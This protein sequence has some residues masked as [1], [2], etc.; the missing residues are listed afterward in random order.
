LQITELFDRKFEEEQQRHIE[1]LKEIRQLQ[2][3]QAAAN[4]PSSNQSLL[5]VQDEDLSRFEAFKQTALGALGELANAGGNFRDVMKGAFSAVA[6]AAQT[7]LSAFILTGKG[8]GQAFKQ[9]AADIIASLAIQSAI[10]AIFETAE[11]FAALAIGDAAGAALHFT[12]AKIYAVVAAGALAVGLAIGAAGGLGGGNNGSQAQG[13]GAF[14]GQQQGPK[15][16]QFTFGDVRG[17]LG[18]TPEDAEFFKNGKGVFG[19]SLERLLQEVELQRLEHRELTERQIAAT[20][21]H[22][23]AAE[24]LVTRINSIPPEDVLSV[25]VDRAPEHVERAVTTRLTDNAGF[26]RNLALATGVS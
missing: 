3:D 14:G 8:G 6:Q 19:A 4:D 15:D 16:F 26:V 9:L 13:A 25:A 24:S 22:A 1:A 12:A 20:D 11:G 21:R 23:N 2:S 10:K 7:V 17:K 18:L 5:G